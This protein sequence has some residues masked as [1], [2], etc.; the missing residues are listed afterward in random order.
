MMFSIATVLAASTAVSAA[1]FRRT[2]TASMTP[3]D[4]YSSSIGVLGCKINTNRVAYWPMPVDCDNI[5]VKLTYEDRSLTL[6]RIDQSGGAHDI[7]YESWNWLAFGK[8]ATADPHTG[9]GIDMQW[10]YVPVS[11]C[12]SIL[13][14]GKLP[15]TASN[16]MDYVASCLSQPNS[17]V[18]KNHKLVNMIDPLC[19]YGFDEECSLNLSVSNQPNCPHT[20]GLMNSPTGQHVTNIAYSTGKEVVA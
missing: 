14:N 2:Q 15:L 6:L 1:A 17:W 20:L 9:G 13:D 16:S 4:S 18:A 8:S 11:E 12:A 5:C 3:H 19:K 10:S 7:S